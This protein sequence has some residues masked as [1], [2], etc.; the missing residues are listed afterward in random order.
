MRFFDKKKVPVL[1]ER[2]S[3]EDFVIFHEN[4]DFLCHSN[5]IYRFL[6]IPKLFL[7]NLS[8][9]FLSIFCVQLFWIFVKYFLQKLKLWT[10]LETTIRKK[11]L[12]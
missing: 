1:G 12:F 2:H 8:S 7:A 9:C 11:Q 10:L 3:F 6:L 4:S 5:N